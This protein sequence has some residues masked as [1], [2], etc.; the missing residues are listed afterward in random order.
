MVGAPSTTVITFHTLRHG[1]HY[2]FV[3][4]DLDPVRSTIHFHL[5]DK[6]DQPLPCRGD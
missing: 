4:L 6:R 1:S 5:R 3:E 2:G